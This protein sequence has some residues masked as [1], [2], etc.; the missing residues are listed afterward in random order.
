MAVIIE[1]GWFGCGTA[2]YSA[3]QCEIVIVMVLIVIV[4]VMVW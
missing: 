1:F 2:G 3:D 4:V